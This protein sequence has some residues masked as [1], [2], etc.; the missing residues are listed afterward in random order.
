MDFLQ[1]LLGKIK[2]APGAIAGGIGDRVRDFKADRAE[3]KFMDRQNE[4]PIGV[5]SPERAAAT[6]LTGQKARG[7]AFNSL[8]DKMQNLD[9]SDSKSV[10]DIQKML[11]MAGITDMEGNALAE[12]GMMGAKTLSALRGA[13]KFRDE[14]VRPEFE[15]T[16]Y[17]AGGTMGINPMQSGGRLQTMEGSDRSGMKN[18]RQGGMSGRMY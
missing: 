2:A 12:D 16:L 1:G 8:M 9:T 18:K 15:G 4:A 11:N 6:N 5:A 3:D 13:Q 7:M 14:M 17:D 10:M